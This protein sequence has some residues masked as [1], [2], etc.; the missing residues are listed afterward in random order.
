M[1]LFKTKSETKK[2][3]KTS[4][5]WLGDYWEQKLG[6][7]DEIDV[8]ELSKY[9]RSIGNFVK[10][11]SGKLIP[12]KFYDNNQGMSATTGEEVFITSKINP[13]TFDSVVGL[14][15]HEGSHI[16]LSD[17]ELLKKLPGMVT[18][19]LNSKMR[20]VVVKARALKFNDDQIIQALMILTNIVEDRR[21]DSFIYRTS[22]GYTG[23][24]DSL[25]DRYWNSEEISDMIRSGQARG[26]ENFEAYMF[27]VTNIVNPYVEPTD[28]AGLQE[29]YDT[30]DLPNIGRL[31]NTEEVLQVA[32]NVFDIILEYIDPLKK[33]KEKKGMKGKGKG[34]S[35]SKGKGESQAGS[36]DGEG[37]PSPGQNWDD[38]SE[39]EEKE[40]EKKDDQ[41]KEEN[42][43]GEGGEGSNNGSNEDEESEDGG[44]S[45]GDEEKE[46]GD[47]KSDED[48]SGGGG[49]EDTD[50]DKEKDGSGGEKDSDED[51]DDE[52][53]GDEEKSQD[54]KSG[55]Q[56]GNYGQDDVEDIKDN[57]KKMLGKRGN[58][59]L[60]KRAA[61]KL[62]EA[63]KKQADF[64]NGKIEKEGL[65]EDIQEKLQVLSEASVKMPKIEFKGSYE[66]LECMVVNHV[67]DSML[68]STLFEC[69]Q[70]RYYNNSSHEKDIRKG[71][72]LGKLLGKKLKVRNETRVTSFPRKNQGRIN[73]RLIAEIGCG[74]TAIFD[75]FTT[76]Q[77]KDAL[78]QIS[79]DASGSM[80]GNWSEV[81]L[82]VSS[83]V[84]AA[85]MSGNIDVV[86]TIR[87]M[88]EVNGRAL[89]LVVVI[90]DS[91]RD[92]IKQYVKV[93][94]R[95]Q[96]NSYT[97]EGLCFEASMN[98]VFKAEGTREQFFLNFSDGMPY[99]PAANYGG[100]NAIEQTR[101]AV[102]KLRGMGMEII[103]YF[104]GGS[105]RGSDG[106]DFRRMYGKDS[107]FIDVTSVIEVARIMNKRF[108]ATSK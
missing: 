15:L 51:G 105:G 68:E 2:D 56:S 95:A 41:E 33:Q 88:Q 83:M 53:D 77:F 87:S 6:K 76:E 13:E 18:T 65:D 42:E 74:S 57:I 84:Q 50:E 90:Y 92:S 67:T 43:G 61:E 3:T 64:I 10:I 60:G 73:K 32:V 28:L 29:I 31:V 39:D 58:R 14:A 94:S 4:S 62:A 26:K 107:Q 22:P 25:Y 86:I 16:L 99:F 79:I 108:L 91:R 72:T 35:K 93:M 55:D 7:E 54:G 46:D 75:Q 101:N 30:I 23:Y 103:S 45:G 47:D 48:G 27:Y 12:V 44:G 98:E 37:A 8:F 78:L 20:D 38:Q 70:K 63:L 19:H 71:L 21:I 104:V 96:P 81:L 97:P 52:D 66:K 40:K 49:D 80:S 69:F 102:K 82:S 24:Y 1:A 100:T 85:K 17:F 11:V 106:N 5:F 89:P 36:G 9:Q 59:K 34:K